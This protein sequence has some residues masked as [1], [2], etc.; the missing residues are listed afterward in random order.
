VGAIETRFT[1]DAHRNHGATEV[2]RFEPFRFK[3]Y[4]RTAQKP[5]DLAEA[6]L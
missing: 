4:D 5:V 1:R 3:G 2:C 6:S